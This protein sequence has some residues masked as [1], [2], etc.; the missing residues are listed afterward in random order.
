M[1]AAGA[2]PERGPGQRRAR[3]PLA[4]GA[5]HRCLTTRPRP[6]P[7]EP[8]T[9]AEPD[10]PP[11]TRRAVKR[12][13]S[14]EAAPMRRPSRN[15]SPRRSRTRSSRRCAPRVTAALGDA[16]IE[17]AESFGTL[18]IRVRPDAWR[19]TAEVLKRDLECD[20]LS[21]IAGID[22]QP[23]ARPDGD[24]GGD[25]SSPVQPT[26]MTFGVTGSDRSVPGV[27]ARPVDQPAL[28]RHG[29]DRRRRH[30][31]ARRSPGCPCTPARTGTS[32]SA[33]RCSASSS[34]ATRA[35]ATSTSRRE[36]EGHPL[37]KDYPLLARE[38]K[39]WPGLVDVEPMPG[40]D[41]PAEAATEAATRKEPTHEHDTT[42]D[43]RSRHS[44]SSRARC[45]TWPTRPSAW[46]STPAT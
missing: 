19:R 7:P 13:R 41:A 36:F 26:E 6:T 16:I 29:E 23:V 17:D 2:H 22:W 14:A 11:P 43:S 46:S 21:F 27:R 18:V 15:P 44:R 4:R 39:P 3:G 45:A 38:V 28:G 9:D 33:G 25:T 24:E 31:P 12:R 34:T 10:A 32:A 8:G 30:Q 35:C 40:E 42:T 37:R 20:Y 1:H 5:D